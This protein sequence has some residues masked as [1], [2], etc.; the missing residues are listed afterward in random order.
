VRCRRSRRQ[1]ELLDAAAEG[2]PDERAG[3]PEGER[4]AGPRGQV[5]PGGALVEVAD[6]RPQAGGAEAGAVE[7]GQ[8]GDEAGDGRLE[9]RAA[10]ARGRGGEPA[11]ADGRDVVHRRAEPL[12]GT[13]DVD[14]PADG[15]PV[16]PGAAVGRRP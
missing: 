9:R 7:L 1:R 5:P 15:P 8:V 14:R 12:F 16:G 4:P 6:L 2:E 13:G 10:V 11:V 3:G